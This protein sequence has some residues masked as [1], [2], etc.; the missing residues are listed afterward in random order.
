M[1]IHPKTLDLNEMGGPL[2]WKAL[3]VVGT[4]Q[5]RALWNPDRSRRRLPANVT[6][7]SIVRIGSGGVEARHYPA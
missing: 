6:F 7:G 1:L 3:L 2:V 4:H 5:K